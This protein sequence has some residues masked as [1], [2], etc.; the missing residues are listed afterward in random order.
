MKKQVLLPLLLI[1]MILAIRPAHAQKI[2]GGISVGANFCQVDGDQFYGF[3]KVGLNFGPMVILP[4]GK[5]KNWSVSM[6]LLY[7]QKGSYHK[8]STDSTYYRL[9]LDYIDIPVMIHFTD[10]KII[11]AGVGVC[12]G[13]LIGKSESELYVVTPHSNFLPYDFSALGE[14]SVRIWNRFWVNVRYQYSILSL[15]TVTFTDPNISGDTWDRD[16]YNNLISLRLTYIFKQELPGKAKKAKG[17]G[18]VVN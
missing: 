8:G 7:S 10:K 13:Q 16:Q 18:E 9:N 14:V 15:R 6:E 17:E 11:S 1:L 2:L 12:Y 3:R 5:N 4:F